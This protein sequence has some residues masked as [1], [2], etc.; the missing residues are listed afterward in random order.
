[1]LCRPA[2]DLNSIVALLIFAGTRIAGGTYQAWEEGCRLTLF[3]A[4]HSLP[5]ANM[6]T[7]FLF[8]MNEWRRL[9]VLYR[10]DN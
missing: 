1:M 4:K 7:R 10:F 2:R 3:L 9:K 5:P 6:I 8:T